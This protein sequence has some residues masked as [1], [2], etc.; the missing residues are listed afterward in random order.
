M[1]TIKRRPTVIMATTSIN[2]THISVPSIP[3]HDNEYEENKEKA[4]IMSEFVALE[5]GLGGIHSSVWLASVGS[6]VVISLVGLLAVAALPLLRG[7]HR[8]A[9]LQLLVSL[10][11]GT[12]VGDSLIHLIP[13]AFGAEHGDNSVVWKGF[14]ATVVI[15]AFFVLDRTMAALGHGHSHGHGHD[16]EEGST[17]DETRT[18]RESTPDMKSSLDIKPILKDSNIPK[19]SLSSERSQDS[20][21]SGM[22]VGVDPAGSLYSLYRH[23]R[24]GSYQSLPGVEPLGGSRVPSPRCRCCTMPSSSLMVIVGDAVHNFADG[25]AVG[26][27]FSL[28]LAA[29]FSTS[30]AVLCHE[31]PHEVGD[32]ALLLSQGMTVRTAIF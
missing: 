20:G 12:L 19:L 18:T 17:S 15:I 11:V 6:I 26:A 16:E 28:S 22:G 32:F 2:R 9:A 24:V 14:T 29:G 8:K 7:K 13:H 23:S 1:T 27:A 3:K 30:V 21:D 25:L 10:A 5:K 4:E 31:L